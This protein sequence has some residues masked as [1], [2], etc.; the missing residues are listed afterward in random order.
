MIYNNI[1]AMYLKDVAV[2]KIGI[3]FGELRSGA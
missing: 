1:A 2:E 3:G